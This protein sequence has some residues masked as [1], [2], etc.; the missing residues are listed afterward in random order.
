MMTLAIWDGGARVPARVR[1]I[2]TAFGEVP[3]TTLVMPGGYRDVSQMLA[4]P[5]PFRIAHRGG[6][7]ERP[8][9]SL[10][11]YTAALYRGYGAAELALAR[12]SDGVWFGLHDA[13]L[14]RTSLGIA[15]GTS[16]P[17]ASMTWDQVRAYPILPPAAHPERA[18]QPY[19]RLTDYL[20]TS[21]HVVTF[22][23]PKHVSW[24][25]WGELLDVMDSHGGPKRWVAK[26]F[27]P[28]IDHGWTNLA[29]SRG[30]TTWGYAYEGDLA[31]LDVWADSYDLLGLNYDASPAAWDQ[32][33]TTGKRVI[34]HIIPTQTA[35]NLAITRGATG[36][37]VSGT[38]ALDLAA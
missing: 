20:P 22:V 12:T 17:A 14:D 30:Y 19:M 28:G 25:Y 4:A 8:E 33:L 35:A 27:A 24:R 3:A 15:G 26:Y 38:E 37:M 18:R 6:S 31:T 21:Q 11:A 29:R 7:I 23:D 13:Y 1:G 9:H 36:L 5:A 2:M 16:L 32:I 34:G 10:Q